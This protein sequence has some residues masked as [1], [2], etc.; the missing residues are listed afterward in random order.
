MLAGSLQPTDAQDDNLNYI[1]TSCLHAIFL[2]LVS[3]LGLALVYKYIYI[4]V[5]IISLI[6]PL[7]IMDINF[8]PH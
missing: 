8:F 7:C 1:P 4:Y 3:V 2:F 5:V 6:S